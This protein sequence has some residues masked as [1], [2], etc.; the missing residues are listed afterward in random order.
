M[1]I[2]MIIKTNNTTATCPSVRRIPAIN[3]PM[4]VDVF[5]VEPLSGSLQFP[6]GTI[7]CNRVLCWKGKSSSLSSINFS[8]SPPDTSAFGKAPW[9]SSTTPFD[10]AKGVRD[11]F[12]TIKFLLELSGILS[13]WIGFE[14]TSNH[15]KLGILKRLL[16]RASSLFDLRS[17]FSKLAGS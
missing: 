9:S 3:L 4:I 10:K 7:C 2:A 14:D 6:L 1:P 12:N 15:A 5:F 11:T 13:S 8:P 17:T 16:G